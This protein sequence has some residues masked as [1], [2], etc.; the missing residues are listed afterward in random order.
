MGSVRQRLT[1]ARMDCNVVLVGDVRVGKSALLNRF[2]NNRFAEAYKPTAFEKSTS[3]AMVAGRR[4]KY[5]I[6][7]TTGSHAVSSS[8]AMAYREADVFLL[9]YKITEPSSLFNAL[10]HWCPEMRAVAP[11]T[12]IILVGCQSDLR[13]NREIL[14]NLSKQGRAPISPEQAL[15]FSQQINAL[16]YVETSA[17]TSTRAAISAFEVAGLASMGKLSKPRSPRSTPSPKALNKKQRYSTTSPQNSLERAAEEEASINSHDE[18]TEHFW[19]RLGSGPKVSESPRTASLS[20]SSRSAS[21]SSKSIPSISSLG[22]KTPK[23]LRKNSSAK[24]NKMEKTM[25]I[26]CQR[27]TADRTYEEIEVEVP[28]PIYETIQLYNDT[29]SLAARGHK[30]RRSFGAKLKN[31]FTK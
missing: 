16:M 19:D 11:S 7:D 12:P 21:L 5:T 13:Q 10:N 2:L 30:E 31:L 25:T 17:K 29:G 3:S 28:V 1:E 4:L 6:W 8:R 18:S 23:S 15:T 22:C 9:C 20:S 26:K 24:D 27:L 14:F